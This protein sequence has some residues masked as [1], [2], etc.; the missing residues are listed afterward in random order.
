MSYRVDKKTVKEQLVKAN[1]YYED[2]W[3]RCFPLKGVRQRPMYPY[4][5]A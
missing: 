4:V 2:A 5:P 1:A 3:L